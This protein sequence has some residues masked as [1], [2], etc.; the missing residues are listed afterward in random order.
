MW[1]AEEVAG[2]NEG[3]SFWRSEGHIL[4]GLAQAVRESGI[5]PAKM[6]CKCDLLLVELRKKLALSRVGGLLGP[7]E[8]WASSDQQ[9]KST[10]EQAAREYGLDVDELL[11]ATCRPP[12]ADPGTGAVFSVDF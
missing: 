7:G 1:L 5:D 2:L 3:E 6:A 9:L 4:P 8:V 10:L 12:V 11:D